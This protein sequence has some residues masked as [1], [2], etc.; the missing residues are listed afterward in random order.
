MKITKV[1]SYYSQ[2]ELVHIVKLETDAGLVGYGDC[3]P[4]D[5]KGNVHVIH[6]IFA[7]RLIGMDPLNIIAIEETLMK[8]NYKINGQIL[9]MAYSG[10][11]IALWDILGKHTG[12]PVCALLGGKVRD[13]IP[14]YGSSMSRDLSPREE[15]DKVIKAIAAYGFEGIKIKVGPRMG[16]GSGIIDHTQDVE[17]VRTVRKAVGDKTA[18]ILDGNSSF[19][20]SEAL[21]LAQLLEEFDITAFEEPCPYYDLHAYIQLA[22]KLPIPLSV[23]EQEFNMHT[24]KD[25]ITQDSCGIYG[26]DLTKCGGFSNANRVSELCAMYGIIYSPHNTNRGLGLMAT[27]QLVLHSVSANWYQEYSIEDL[28]G[29]EKYVLNR[30]IIKNGTFTPE[31]CAG[32]G[33]QMDEARMEKDLE[34]AVSQ[35]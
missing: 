19:R 5:T 23:G 6:E 24:M 14:F 29:R 27:N 13:T 7:K 10:I 20:P 2:K 34:R 33:A 15:A 32:I 12:L 31:M 3:S 26:A 1:T 16:N 17:K 21:R 28:A 4:M 22:K 30:P 9:G 25:F 18:V 35:V 8:K 11:D